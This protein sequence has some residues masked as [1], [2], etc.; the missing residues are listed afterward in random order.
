M[1]KKTKDIIDVILG[2]LY[3]I[4]VIFCIVI[5]L[6]KE[7][8]V[9]VAK[10]LPFL[11]MLFAFFI[12]LN[13]NKMLKL[14]NTAQKIAY[15]IFLYFAVLILGIVLFYLINRYYLTIYKITYFLPILEIIVSLF[16]LIKNKDIIRPFFSIFIFVIAIILVSL[17]Y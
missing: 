4:L 3:G 9:S 6:N 10:I 13:V 1:D 12:N 16:N 14:E 5:F 17:I 15:N 7:R 8:V 11:L 2:V